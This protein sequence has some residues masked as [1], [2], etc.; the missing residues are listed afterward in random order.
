MNKSYRSAWN[1]TLGAWVVTSE[2]ASARGRRGA[3]STHDRA[4]RHRHG[5][6]AGLHDRRLVMD[7]PDPQRQRRL[8]HGERRTEPVQ[9]V[10]RQRPTPATGRASTLARTPSRSGP[11]PPRPAQSTPWRSARKRCRRSGFDRVGIWLGR[12]WR[13]Q[14]CDRE[15]NSQRRP[16][17][18]HRLSGERDQFRPG[19]QARHGLLCWEQSSVALGT[20]ATSTGIAS[21]F[22]T[23]MNRTFLIRPD[24]NHEVRT[25]RRPTSQSPDTK[26]AHGVDTP[27]GIYP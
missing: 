8:C 23:R 16:Q 19:R 10:A 27:I 12:T 26:P 15:R 4:G 1:E 7:L 18:R 21:C 9:R 3:G 24:G 22:D 6:P 17:Y 5:C 2:I 20:S 11:P 13:R 14:Y 25:S